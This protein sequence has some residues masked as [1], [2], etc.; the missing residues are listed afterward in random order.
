MR[1]REIGH[2]RQS[3]QSGIQTGFSPRKLIL[4]HFLDPLMQMLNVPAISPTYIQISCAAVFVSLNNSSIFSCCC[5][6]KILRLE[7]QLK[8]K[9]RGREIGHAR[10]TFQ[11]GIQTGVPISVIS[12]NDEPDWK[13]C[14]FTMHAE[15]AQVFAAEKEK[16]VKTVDLKF[17]LPLLTHLLSRK[18]C[19]FKC[20]FLDVGCVSGLTSQKS[21]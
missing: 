3:F 4:R 1:G 16:Y 10:Q 15:M 20:Q 13:F 12:V 7:P 11:S 5:F 9:V 18:S 19:C 8:F 17:Y 21:L 14:V 6:A 2:A